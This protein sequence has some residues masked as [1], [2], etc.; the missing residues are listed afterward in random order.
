M[1][2]TTSQIRESITNRILESLE[3]GVKPWMRPWTIDPNSGAPS[4][5]VSKK[6]YQGINPLLLDLA[7]MERGYAGKYWATFGQWREQGASVKKDEKA[8][9]IVFYSQVKAKKENEEDEERRYGL[10]KMYAVF[11]IDQVGG[12]SVDK[13][14]PDTTG[15]NE[16]LIEYTLADETIKATGAEIKHGGSRACYSSATKGIK[17]PYK[18][19][20]DAEENYYSTAF[21]ELSHWADAALGAKL[22]KRFGDEDYAFGELVAEISACYLS[23]ACNIP[24]GKRWDDSVSYLDNWIKA[25][26]GDH[27]W[28]MKAAS[29]ATQVSDYIL[30]FSRQEEV[31]EV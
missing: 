18:S 22:G 26:K 28:I 27:S 4:S 16:G 8:T 1:G 14:R 10:L 21:H 20:F 19:K 31:A 12:E 23:E 11:C 6:K 5:L 7:G 9:W 24:K 25:M 17:L 30:N 13:F 2:M 15:T 3:K 29:R